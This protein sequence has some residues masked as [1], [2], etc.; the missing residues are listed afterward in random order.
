MADGA[1]DN[2]NPA[3]WI[4]RSPHG[5]HYLVTNTGTHNLGTGPFARRLWRAATATDKQRGP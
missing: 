3:F 1:S 2:P 4:W 5:T